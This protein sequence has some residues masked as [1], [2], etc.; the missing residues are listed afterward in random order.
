MDLITD[1]PET[2]DGHDAIMVVVDRLT[3]LA[4]F[5]PC[6]KESSSFDI[7]RLFLQNIFVHHGTPTTIVSDRDPRFTSGFWAEFCRLLDIKRNL[8]TPYHPESD[9]QT[10][11][12]NRILEEYLRHYIAPHQADWSAWL[13]TAQFAI[14]S[15]VQE[16]TGFSPFFLT[17]GFHPTHPGV[18]TDTPASN[19]P[20]HPPDEH[21]AHMTSIQ[22]LNKFH[23]TLQESL[24]LAKTA[25]QAAQQRQKHYADQSR[26]PVQYEVGARV[27]LNTLHVGLKC[28]GA[29]KLW[30]RFIG[31]FPILARVGELAYKLELPP[32][33]KI[34]N[35]LHVSKLRPFFDDGRVQPPPLPEL[36]DGELEYEVE[37]VYNHRDVKI[38]RSR[39]RREYLVRWKGYGVEHDEWIPVA[40]FG[41]DLECIQEYWEG[42]DGPADEVLG[43]SR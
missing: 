27:L 11:R 42:A 29:R 28:K 30:P 7:A 33:L 39:T 37:M 40:N 32:A 26:R 10:E 16:S 22:V 9:G 19:L 23:T 38:G 24:A 5:L 21:A 4:H 20:N 1:L 2:S 6:K 12:M 8:T 43:T 36:A 25:I 35:V 15:A 13:P 18:L 17:Y 14:N 3:K 31:P 41:D 34:H